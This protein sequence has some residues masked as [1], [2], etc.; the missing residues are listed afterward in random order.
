MILTFRYFWM[1]KA[2]WKFMTG[3]AYLKHQ[4]GT[5]W[6]HIKYQIYNYS[7]LIIGSV[8]NW[9]T[10]KVYKPIYNYVE[11]DNMFARTMVFNRK[12][13]YRYKEKDKDFFVESRFWRYEKYTKEQKLKKEE[14]DLVIRNINLITEYSEKTG[15]PQSVF[16]DTID[17]RGTRIQIANFSTIKKVFSNGLP[18][19]KNIKKNTI[20]FFE[21]LSV[22]YAWNIVKKIIY[23][24]V[25][26]FR[27]KNCNETYLD[28]CNVADDTAYKWAFIYNYR[29]NEKRKRKRVERLLRK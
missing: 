1:F 20:C 11:R 13:S 21:F 5:Y 4:L 16:L 24:K 18:S 28:S 2:W 12:M 3:W 17:I 26:K 7:I 15:I 8:F 14:E 9:F 6:E 22:Y 25:K 19:W 29:W 10:Q 27:R 23:N